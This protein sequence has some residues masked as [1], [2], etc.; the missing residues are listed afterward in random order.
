MYWTILKNGVGKYH[1]DIT[2]MK[3]VIKGAQDILS[4]IEEHE[5][6]EIKPKTTEV[7]QALRNFYSSLLSGKF[8][9]ERPSGG[10]SLPFGSLKPLKEKDSDKGVAS[11]H[12]G[13]LRKVQGGG[14]L[15]RLKEKEEEGL[16]S[17]RSKFCSQI[18]KAKHSRNQFLII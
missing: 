2:D 10:V 13:R 9:G 8:H 4:N 12:R 6:F 17:K 11:E 5:Y 1:G 15:A 3:V 16:I 14:V 18:N 7:H